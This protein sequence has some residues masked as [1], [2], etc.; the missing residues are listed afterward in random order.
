MNSAWC[1]GPRKRVD[2]T[3]FNCSSCPDNGFACRLD[4]IEMIDATG[5]IGTDPGSLNVYH[6]RGIECEAPR[7]LQINTRRV[8]LQLRA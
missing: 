7:L 1:S 2:E 3:L 4:R 6:L 5:D 8:A